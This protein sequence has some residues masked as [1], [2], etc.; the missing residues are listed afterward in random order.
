MPKINKTYRGKEEATTS[1]PSAK[2]DAEINDCQGKR[3]NKIEIW[4][5]HEKLAVAQIDEKKKDWSNYVTS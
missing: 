5:I 1:L 2:W 4:H 3:N